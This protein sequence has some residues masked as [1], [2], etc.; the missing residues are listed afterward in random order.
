[1]ESYIWSEVLVEPEL[2]FFL[3]K[4]EHTAN[5]RN[6]ELSLKVF[7]DDYRMD[8][9]HY[10]YGEEILGCGLSGFKKHAGKNFPND[11]PL[12]QNKGKFIYLMQSSF[13]NF[14]KNSQGNVVKILPEDIQLDKEKIRAFFEQ[15]VENHE[16]GHNLF[17]RGDSDLE[18]SKPSL[19]FTLKI[20]D[21]IEQKNFDETRVKPLLDLMNL[22]FLRDI[23]RGYTNYKNN[24]V[25]KYTLFSRIVLKQMMQTKLISWNEQ[26]T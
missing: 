20:L 10:F 17:F 8:G 21:E 15:F 9:V 2:I 3:K 24:P 16:F 1:M 12:S 4:Y 6:K 26:K 11:I 19:F 23:E 13:E 18:E 22:E 14:F 7:G 25:Y 5:Q